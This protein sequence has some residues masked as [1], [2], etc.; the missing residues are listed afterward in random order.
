VVS[1]EFFDVRRR[2]DYRRLANEDLAAGAPESNGERYSCGGG[3]NGCAIDPSGT[4]SICV[5]SH[6]QGYNIRE[7]SFM[8]GWEGRMREIRA[9]KKT[10]P[11]ICDRCQ[12]QSLCSMCPANGEL[13]NGDA[14]SP[15]EFL[16]QVAHL[17]AY[18]LGSPVP[19]H[20]DCPNCAA[21]AQQNA[22]LDSAKRIREQAGDAREWRER[23][24]STPVL[25]VLQPA[26]AQGAACR[27]CSAH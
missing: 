6:Q 13:E 22:L 14:E 12:I 2:E 18:A 8:E 11:T 19:E 15:V 20:G 26:S 21:G 17:R 23:Q 16:C 24:A 3:L 4:M 7:G 1:L 25:H 9:Q 10:R 27:S 5:I